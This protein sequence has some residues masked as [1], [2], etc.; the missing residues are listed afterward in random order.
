MRTRPPANPQMT[1][2]YVGLQG[3]SHDFGSLT[4]SSLLRCDGL[5]ITIVELPTIA[6]KMGANQNHARFKAWVLLAGW[7]GLRFGEEGEL[8]REDFD[9]ACATVSITRAFG[10]RTDPD[11]PDADRCRIGQTK[12][13]ETRE[14]DIPPHIQQD[15]KDHLALFVATDPE[16]LLFVPPRG[17]CHLDDRV[18]NK[19][20]FQKAAKDVGRSDL[21]AHDLRRFAGT[22]NANVGA[23]L[24]ENMKRLGHRTVTAA[25]LYQLAADNGG[26]K[27]A[28]DLSAHALAQ[29]EGQGR[30]D[31]G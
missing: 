22:T 5:A 25:M 14:V 13:K 28:A 31:A 23:T 20:V 19:D 10:H 12:T 29:L 6:H 18:C 24:A 1:C 7:C 3:V 26:K 21:A 15:V 30:A 27:L 9:R 4:S 16:S 11:D 8:R 2:D 17:G